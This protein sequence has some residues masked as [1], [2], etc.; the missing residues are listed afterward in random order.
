MQLFINNYIIK[1]C[2]DFVIINIALPLIETY[3]YFKRS[4]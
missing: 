2:T 4:Y 1:V 3:I